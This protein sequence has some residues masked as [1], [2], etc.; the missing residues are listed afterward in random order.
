MQS[1]VVDRASII[2]NV[3]PIASAMANK[4]EF[5]GEPTL[6]RCLISVFHNLA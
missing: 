6:L 4:A 1:I 3:T 2:W 5:I